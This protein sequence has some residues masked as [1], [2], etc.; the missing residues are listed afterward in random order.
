MRKWLGFILLLGLL[1]FPSTV[2]AQ[3]EAKLESVNIELWSEYD[4]PSML[5]INEF[6]VSQNTTLPAKV[7]VRFPKEGNLMAVAVEK[8]SKLFNINFDGPEEQGNWQNI[9]LKVDTRDKYR[10]E[11]YQPLTREGN[12]RFFK[13]QWFGGYAV[14]NLIVNMLIPADSTNVVA[15]PIISNTSISP[16][17]LYLVGSVAENRLVAGRSYEFQLEYTRESDAV[18][19]TGQSDSVQPSEPIG[20]DTSGRVS[21][22][23]MPY[24]IGGVGVALI[25]VALFFYWRSTQSE[26]YSSARAGSRRRRHQSSEEDGEGQAYCHE[27]GARA[28]SGDRFCRTCGSRLR[29]VQE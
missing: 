17:G 24:I 25:A 18:T 6:V 7:T 5:I 13:Y 23:R 10:V 19:N 1:L 4:Q 20:P 14:D 2:D 21:I 8:D 29:N 12:K 28:H 11:Y 16:N 27:C 26:A 22:D 15:S 9:T 3:D